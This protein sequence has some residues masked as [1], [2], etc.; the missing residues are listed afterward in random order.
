MLGDWLVVI[1]VGKFETGCNLRT[2]VTRKI[3]REDTQERE[4]IMR[5][6]AQE[7]EEVDL[8]KKDGERSY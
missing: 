8:S 1:R 4:V 5:L 7:F 6:W 2:W 3:Q